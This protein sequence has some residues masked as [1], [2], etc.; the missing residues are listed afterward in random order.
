MK[1]ISLAE[2]RNNIYDLVKAYPIGLT[3]YGKV[4]CTILPP[5]SDIAAEKIVDAIAQKANDVHHSEGQQ[6][7]T[8]N[9][10][11]NDPSEALDKAKQNMEN[12]LAQH[13]RPV[14]GS[15]GTTEYHSKCQANGCQLPA[16]GTVS[17]YNGEES[18]DMKLCSRH[19]GAAK[20]S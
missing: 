4:V 17:V 6:T 10:V 8:E 3:R 18:K 13:S 2:F 16:T 1:K 7:A 11:H 15:T 20:R 14:T 19:L 5:M 12:L 9:H